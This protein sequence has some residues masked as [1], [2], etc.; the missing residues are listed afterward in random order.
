M[1]KLRSFLLST[2][3][4]LTFPL[5]G[6]SSQTINTLTHDELLGENVFAQTP[7]INISGYSPQMTVDLRPNCPPVYRQGGLSACTAFA[8]AKGVLEIERRTHGYPAPEMSALYLYYYERVAEKDV[9]ADD[10]AILADAAYVL[11]KRGCATD[12]TMPYN[13]KAFATPPSQIAEAEAGDY[14]VTNVKQVFTTSDM[15]QELDT[16]HPVLIG[17]TLYRSF[18]SLETTYT[19]MVSLPNLPERDQPIGFHAAVL[20]GYDIETK[21]FL[22]RNSWGSNWGA[23]G[24]CYVPFDYIEH[25]S[26]SGWSIR[27]NNED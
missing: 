25:Y 22:V 13:T 5:M 14:R 2:M 21:L 19:G 23:N 9:K 17:L 26:F 11:L 3:T 1:K 15:M 18:G 7:R 8:G 12:E 16:G 24:Y 10:G 27:L 20:V 4:C 6:F